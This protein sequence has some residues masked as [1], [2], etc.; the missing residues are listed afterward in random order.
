MPP[1]RKLGAKISLAEKRPKRQHPEIEAYT[2]ISALAKDIAKIKKQ[3][4]QYKAL[5]QQVFEMTDQ[6]HVNFV[7]SKENADVVLEKVMKWLQT[8]QEAH[9]L[10]LKTRDKAIETL[11]AVD[12]LDDDSL[13]GAAMILTETE[14]KLAAI[15]SIQNRWQRIVRH[16]STAKT[17]Q[18]H[19]KEYFLRFWRQWDKTNTVL[20]ERITRFKEILQEIENI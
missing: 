18:Q 3:E 8:L 1:K 6:V 5:I 13:K 17:I 11:R 4:F 12:V 19:S 15:E 7:Y 20:H 10:N 2:S 9:G 14:T 16:T